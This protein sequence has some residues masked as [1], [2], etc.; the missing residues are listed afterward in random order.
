MSQARIEPAIPASEMPQTQVLD[1]EST[2]IGTID[3]YFYVKQQDKA[4]S[5]STDKWGLFSEQI[6]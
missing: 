6:Q 1:G 4:T 2:G 5:Y 3:S